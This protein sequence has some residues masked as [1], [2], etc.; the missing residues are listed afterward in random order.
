[1]LTLKRSHFKGSATPAHEGPGNSVSD[2]GEKKVYFFRKLSQGISK[3]ACA[4]ALMVLLVYTPVSHGYT[5]RS[6]TSETAD[7][8]QEALKAYQ[9]G[10][11]E[12]AAAKL[13]MITN[14]QLEKDPEIKAK[15]YLLL[16]ACREKTG[17]SEKAKDYFMQ[18][19]N[20]IEEGEI[21]RVPPLPG[22]EPESF[23]SYREIFSGGSFFTYKQPVP[24]S[25]VI[26]NNVIHAPRKSAEKKEKEKKKKK[27]P[28]MLAVGAVVIIG[29]VAVLLLSAKK[30]DNPSE[31]KEI[32]WVNI[33]AGEFLM[34]DNFNEGDADEQPVHTV[35]L[36]EYYISKYE[37]TYT[38]YDYFCDETGREKLQDIFVWGPAKPAVIFICPRKPSGRKRREGRINIAIP[39]GIVRPTAR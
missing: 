8:F 10:S 30:G 9:S 20:A 22:I 26:K 12:T 33:P 18:L 13:A 7:F 19:K 38:Q 1:M 4:L 31:F 37:I 2:R 6:S 14:F 23:P 39:G 28:W 35:Y 3:K 5:G 17:E 34:G 15:I 27:F 36:N 16:G 32:D 11:Y 21:D 25:E 29:T 24:V